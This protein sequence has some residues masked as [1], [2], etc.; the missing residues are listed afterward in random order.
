ME[1]AHDTGAAY[2]S[3]LSRRSRP[4]GQKLGFTSADRNELATALP[5]TRQVRLF[6]DS[7]QLEREVAWSREI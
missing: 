6:I 2:A 5:Q 4:F 3:S 1:Q 7:G